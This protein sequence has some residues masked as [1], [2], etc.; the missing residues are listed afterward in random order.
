MRWQSERALLNNQSEVKKKK[1]IP[2]I[3][4][5]ARREKSGHRRHAARLLLP[6]RCTGTTESLNQMRINEFQPTQVPATVQGCNMNNV[7]VC[8][9]SVGLL[10]DTVP[11]ASFMRATCWNQRRSDESEDHRKPSDRPGQTTGRRMGRWHPRSH[12]RHHWQRWWTA[13]HDQHQ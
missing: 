10:V 3:N 13:R 9:L 11:V 8:A 6:T 7:N 2:Q 12:R 4:R 5:T 1:G